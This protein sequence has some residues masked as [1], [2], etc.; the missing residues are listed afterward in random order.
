MTGRSLSAGSSDGWREC[1]G[2]DGGGDPEIG[3]RLRPCLD[4]LETF[5]DGPLLPGI[6]IEL[7]PGHTRGSS[8]VIFTVG[9]RRVVI[10]GD[11]AHSPVQLLETEWN[12]PF[13]VDGALA[14]RTRQRLVRDVQAHRDTAVAGMHFPGLRFGR[15]EGAEGRRRWRVPA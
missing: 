12:T 2:T 14:R 5:E 9:A 13:D 3:E 11:V 4:R 1:C 7:A 15:V 6:A 10:L 8:L